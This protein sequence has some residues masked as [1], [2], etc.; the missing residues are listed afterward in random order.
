MTDDKVKAREVVIDQF[1]FSIQRAV[2]VRFIE[3]SAYLALQSEMTQM[4]DEYD[5][6]LK[7][8]AQEMLK[9]QKER[10]GL[11]AALI[12]IRDDE[13]GSLAGNPARW[14]STIAKQALGEK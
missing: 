9:A 11:R 7:L 8:A 5:D 13:Y 2:P 12:K 14:P 10:D 1:D 4:K 3:H 6:A